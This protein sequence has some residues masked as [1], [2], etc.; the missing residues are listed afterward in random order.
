M[1]RGLGSL[2]FSCQKYP[3][4][5]FVDHGAKAHPASC[6]AHFQHVLP[7]SER[8]FECISWPLDPA[9]PKAANFHS[10]SSHAIPQ[11]GST[12]HTRLR[13]LSRPS[14]GEQRC[15]WLGWLLRGRVCWWSGSALPAGLVRCLAK[16]RSDGADTHNSATTCSS[17]HAWLS[18]LIFKW[19]VHITNSPR[20]RIKD[21][22]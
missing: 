4:I 13:G 12:Q 3:I 6:S 20:R 8:A 5:R 11:M 10:W 1:L 19:L 9:H 15:P 14:E 21:V 18:D 17:P 2:T 16:I 22:G 7:L